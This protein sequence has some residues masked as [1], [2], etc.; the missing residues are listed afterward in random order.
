MKLTYSDII[1]RCQDGASDTSTAIKTFFKQRINEKYEFVASKLNTFI[2]VYY[3]T[4][5]T[6]ENQ[7]YYY[8]PPNLR[9]IES[10]KITIGDVDYPLEPINSQSE[11]DRI[12]SIEFQGGVLP[13]YFFRRK[14]DYGIF[15][16]PQSDDYTITIAYKQRATPLYF[17]DYTT[18]TVAVT[19]NDQ[20]VTVTTGNFSTGAIKAGFWFSLADTNGEPRGTWYRIGSVTD[21]SNLELETYFEEATETG[22]SYIIGQCPEIPEEGHTLLSDG[23]LE[24][25][26]M[27]KQKDPETAKTYNNKF[28][29]GSPNVTASFAKKNDGDY[30]GLIGLIAAYRDRDDS[31]IVHRNPQPNYSLDG[32]EDKEWATTIS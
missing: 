20:T 26:F 31:I 21:A 10:I 28:W 9:S 16:I 4:A 12:N 5:S 19:Q 11:W 32:D 23:A 7:Q 1:A 17:E 14:D 6:E 22:A 27:L 2:R 8:N 30:G 15:P 29:T 25:F 3:K 13:K 18:G 24:D